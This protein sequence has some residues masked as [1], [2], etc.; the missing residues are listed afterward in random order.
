MALPTPNPSP[1]KGVHNLLPFLTGRS[2]EDRKCSNG[3][4]RQASAE[5]G[6]HSKWSHRRARAF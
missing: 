1:E 6:N 2:K 4:C 3:Q 5:S